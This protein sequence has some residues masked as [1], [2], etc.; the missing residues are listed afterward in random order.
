MLYLVDSNTSNIF[1]KCQPHSKKINQIFMKEKT[2]VV[3]ISNDGI[4]RIT[5]MSPEFDDIKI[6]L[7][8]FELTSFC[9]R[10]AFNPSQLEFFVGT[11]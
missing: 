4:L 9:L 10:Y 6:E 11:L 1:K 3:T 5:S 8:E 2:A 7:Q